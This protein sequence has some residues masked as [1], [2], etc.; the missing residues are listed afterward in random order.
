LEK[1][2]VDL[3]VHHH[4]CGVGD[5]DLLVEELLSIGLAAEHLLLEELDIDGEEEAMVRLHAHQFAVG[6]A[7]ESPEP[8]GQSLVPEAKLPQVAHREAQT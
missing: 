2:V 5:A 7:E 6:M 1:R 8:L 3:V 4:L